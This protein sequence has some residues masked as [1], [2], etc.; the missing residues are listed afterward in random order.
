MVVLPVWW[1][2]SDIY[3]LQKPEVFVHSEKVE[4]ETKALVGTS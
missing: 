3:R 1:V 4:H 2:H